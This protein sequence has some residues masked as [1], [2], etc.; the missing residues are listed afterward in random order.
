[1]LAKVQK[2]SEFLFECDV[3]TTDATHARFHWHMEDATRVRSHSGLQGVHVWTIGLVRYPWP[4]LG[5]I[6]PRVGLH[7]VGLAIRCGIHQPHMGVAR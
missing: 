3:V 6:K 4:H 1:M 7:D 2:H 5:S